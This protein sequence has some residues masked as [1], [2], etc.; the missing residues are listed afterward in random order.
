MAGFREHIT[1]SSLCGVGVGLVSHLA[2]DFTIPEAGVAACLTGVGGMMPDL[3]SETGRPVRELF[4]LLGAVAPLLFLGRLL[5]LLH[6]SPEPATMMLGIIS[7][8]LGVRYGGAWLIGKIAVHRGMFHSIPAMLIAGEIVF[9]TSDAFHKPVKILFACG[10][11]IGFLSHLV[12]D[13]IYSVQ[14]NGVTVKLKKSAGTAMKWTSSSM[15]ANILTYGLLVTL[16]YMS[17]SLV[18]EIIESDKLQAEQ[19][20]AVLERHVMETDAAPVEVILR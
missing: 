6:I 3:D 7:M 9:L 15:N 12:L 16:S 17:L 14:W 10:M 8:Y 11:M 19:A 20:P 18:A 4:A 1:T 5:A 2:Y 13:E